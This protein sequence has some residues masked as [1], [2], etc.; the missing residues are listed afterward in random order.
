MTSVGPCTILYLVRLGFPRL[1]KDEKFA[2]GAGARTIAK[3]DGGIR[4][5]GP[6]AMTFVNPVDDPKREAL[7]T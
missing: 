6:F 1:S 2:F 7:V 4:A 3:R 5:D